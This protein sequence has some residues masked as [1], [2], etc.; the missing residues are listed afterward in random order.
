MRPALAPAEDAFFFF[1]VGFDAYD[2][3]QRG[4]KSIVLLLVKV[5]VAVTVSAVRW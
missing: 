4:M 5:V 1:C 2:E 3:R